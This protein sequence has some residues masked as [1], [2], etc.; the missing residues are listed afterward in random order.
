MGRQSLQIHIEKMIGPTN[1]PSR[2]SVLL[3]TAR[4]WVVGTLAYAYFYVVERIRLPDAQGYERLW[5]WQ[6]FFSHSFVSL[7]SWRS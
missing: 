3:A 2:R 5:S 4:I 1:T 6:L 7:G